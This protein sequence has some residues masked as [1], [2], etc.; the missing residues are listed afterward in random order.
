M[1]EI[2]FTA[3]Q[4]AAIEHTGTSISVSAAA[5]SGKTKVLVERL[6]RMIC[7]EDNPISVKDII[8][9]TFTND[10][11]ANM[12]LRLTKAISEKI[13]ENPKN[14]R[15]QRE[16]ALIPVSHICTIDSYA[17][18]LVREQS[19]KLGI[20]DGFSILD[21]RRGTLMFKKAVDVTFEKWYKKRVDDI[22]RL[23]D[24]FSG[25][26]KT[27]DDGL[28]EA[29]GKI[30]AFLRTIPFFKDFISEKSMRY[31][32]PLDIKTDEFFKEYV[33][34]LETETAKALSH[35]DKALEIAENEIGYPKLSAQMRSENE[36]FEKLLKA[37]ENFSGDFLTELNIN[38]STLESRT[39]KGQTKTEN[40][41]F[42]IEVLKK[43]REA[44]KDILEDLTKNFFTKEDITEDYKYNYEILTLL[45]ELINDIDD[46]FTGIKQKNNVIDF[47]DAEQMAV[48]L[49]CEKN[50]DK[51]T[52]SPLSR[53]IA[54]KTA[55]IMIDEYQDSNN[56]QD[57]LF[58]L[59]S[60]SP[61]SSD[62]FKVNNNMFIVGD[63][64][65]AIYSFR[66][67]NPGI[68]TNRLNNKDNNPY[69][70]KI[71]LKKN[72]R[73]SE[74]VINFINA[75]FSPLMKSD[76]FDGIIYDDDALVY[77]GDYSDDIERKTEFIIA[78][79]DDETKTA[80]AQATA[81]TIKKMLDEKT[82]VR[83]NG[84]YRPCEPKDFCI[85][86]RDKKKSPKFERALK[87]LG[88]PYTAETQDTYLKAYEIQVLINFL[89]ILDNPLQD[90]PLVSVLLSP[91]FAFSPDEI[92]EIRLTGTH[93]K[94]YKSLL[95]YKDGHSDVLA[96]KLL[97]FTDTLIKIKKTA[98]SKTLPRLI[99]YIYDSTDFLN[100]VMVRFSD[101]NTKRANLQLL[102]DYA[103][104]FESFSYG[105]VSGFLS[106]LGK[107]LKTEKDFQNAGGNNDSDNAVRIK[108]IH[109][110]KGLE[111]P[112]VFLANPTGT[113]NTKDFSNYN[114]LK[115]LN[116]GLAVK[117]QN[118]VT[119][120]KYETFPF[121]SIKKIC[122]NKLRAEELRILYVALT[123]AQEK[124]FIVAE[125]TKLSAALKKFD[126]CTQTKQSD[127]L[128]SAV[129]SCNCYFEFFV[130]AFYNENAFAGIFGENTE[131]ELFKIRHFYP[132]ENETD[133]PENDAQ[134]EYRHNKETEKLLLHRFSQK[135]P[136]EDENIPAKI[137]VTELTKP[138]NTYALD[139]INL[140]ASKNKMTAAEKG[141]VIHKFMQLCD[142][143]AAA[144][145]VSDEI[146]RLCS[147]GVF[148]EREKSAL[149]IFM[150]KGFFGSEIY[151]KYIKNATKIYREIEIYAKISD[152]PLDESFKIEYNIRGETFIQ[153]IADCV[154][155]TDSGLVLID[156]KTNKNFD[157]DITHFTEHLRQLYTPQLTIYAAAAEKIFGEKVTKV[158]LYSFETMTVI[159]I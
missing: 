19:S 53:E 66:S 144:R 79:D 119:L 4:A 59:I 21:E 31:N 102:I 2:K 24:V 133:E 6:L 116:Y 80:D 22:N 32:I 110:S 151:T 96:A 61:D 45:G 74:D 140:T 107:I 72:F 158:C 111:F 73:S 69:A 41:K 157:G 139:S 104:E 153:G 98:A 55:C 130:C 95:S 12:K 103:K 93:D 8:V 3:E 120:K 113:F 125:D 129:L 71:A 146:E 36:A 132:S 27:V 99:Q 108:T 40:E 30:Y 44:Y 105:G 123:R 49:L 23:I 127:E 9:V 159:D 76:T 28:E 156:Y 33:K 143:N 65:Q 135:Y 7:N 154:V 86:M 126:E 58:T 57:L 78:H 5:G 115:D 128:K 155:K 124:L 121:Y 136:H 52:P 14:T 138:K 137:A 83:H 109:K 134:S 54:E 114:F 97:T 16:A 70:E 56:I 100:N 112:F 131:N 20:A 87:K 15:L 51:I 90:I 152:I 91:M 34:S 147:E 142:F 145:S 26:K 11:A 39:P 88:I 35:S 92:A 77:S 46:N 84:E 148:S 94:F 64:K 67:S 60:K 25:A 117:Y 42:A 48:S 101:G 38:F 122:R 37:A 43:H 149:D 47:A 150:L 141:T 13:A 106:Y 89:K 85:L 62:N 63:I 10:A 81:L 18:E 50:E 82:P 75:L 118:R 1:Q 68:F 29:V 17:I